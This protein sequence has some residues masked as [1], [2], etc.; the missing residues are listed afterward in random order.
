[1]NTRVDQAARS[2]QERDRAALQRLTRRIARHPN[3]YRYHYVRCPYCDS[4]EI[5]TYMRETNPHGYQPFTRCLTCI[6][7]IGYA[8]AVDQEIHGLLN[9]ICYTLTNLDAQRELEATP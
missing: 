1:M 4:T 2:I 7:H 6:A 9:R 8:E 3:S 5:I